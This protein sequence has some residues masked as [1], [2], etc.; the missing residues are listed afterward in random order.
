MN[1]N[2][3]KY[4]KKINRFVL[5]A[6]VALSVTASSIPAFAETPETSFTGSSDASAVLN[7]L[8]YN[9]VRN[10]NTWAKEAIYEQ[11]ALDIIKGFGSQTF[12]LNTTLSKEQAISIA[13]R[14]AG[15][16]ADAQKAAEA[17]DYARSQ[18]DKKTN[19]ISMWS[20]GYLQLAA[21]EGLISQTDLNDAFTQDQT[22]L[23]ATA[24][25]RS[26]PAQRQEMAFYIAKVLK[27]DPAYE[28]QE[29]FNS[30]SDWSLA[31]PTKVPYIEAVLKNN[32]MNGSN[33]HF[34][35]TQS[36][37]REQGAQ[38]AKNASDI[39]LPMRKFI[40]YSGVI[41]DKT[42][43]SDVSVSGSINRTLLSVRNSNGN[44]HV[45]NADNPVN[46]SSM[47]RNEANGQYVPNNQKELVVYR[48]G[49]IGNS[50]LLR[51]GDS[52]EYITT[53]D[54]TVKFV[55]VIN[56][57]SSSS[58]IAV[59]FESIDPAA[60]K[61]TVT[62]LYKTNS[63]DGTGSVMNSSISG[64][65]AIYSF[66]NNV[67]VNSD[68]GISGINEITSG[69]TG[70]VT[71]NN[72]IV[73]SIRLSNLNGY[74]KETGVVSGIVQDNNPQLG[75]IT[76]YNSDGS[77][78]DP[79]NEKQLILGRTYN[80]NTGD[81][82]V[83]KNHSPA[84]I[85]DIEPG[86]T[87]FLKTDEVGTVVS[88]SAVDNYQTKYAK[89][90]SKKPSSIAVRFDDGSQQILDVPSQTPVLSD[91]KLVGYGSVKDG[92]RVR[93]MLHI[94]NGFTRIKEIAIEGSKAGGQLISNVYKGTIS[95]L[96]DSKNSLVVQNVQVFDNG[97][98]QRT[99]QKGF[100]DIKLSKDCSIYLNDKVIDTKTL[101]RYS[102]GNEAYI[103]VKKDYGN[104]ENAV[105]VS[106]RNSGDT[107][108]L[109]DDSISNAVP[110]SNMFS[111]MNSYKTVSYGPGS[112]II[113]DGRLVTGSSLT[114]DDSAYIVANLNN[115]GTDKY[116]AGVVQVSER[117][118]SNFIQI[119]RARISNINENQDFTVESF[120]QL[121]GNTWQYN[122]T[123]KT[124]ILKSNTR[125]LDD[126]GVVNQRDFIS[127]GDSSYVGKVVYILANNLDTV[128]ISEAPF[129]NALVKGTIY[130]T[131]NGGTGSGSSGTATFKLRNAKA[132]NPNTNLWT[133][134]NTITIGTLNDTIVIKNNS[135]AT[136]DDLKNGD[137]IRV[138]KA[139]NTPTGNGY[140][141]FV[142]K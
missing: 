63:A 78:T 31:D 59:R 49:Q 20:D 36:L 117:P 40:K 102:K 107:E 48:N 43:V 66:S 99:D 96:N 32:I 46:S 41:E 125:I 58:Y 33:G 19:A 37:T 142:E 77:G 6:A 135:I 85:E 104:E 10:S 79:D 109:Y 139:D 98:W 120:S 28:Q 100:K 83:Q 114:G 73:T 42:A 39:V 138:I 52:I 76:L 47:G 12:G 88:I 81:L 128:M 136:V 70:V 34:Y 95:Y 16:E 122:N 75:Y 116:Y 112:I 45:I 9:D 68:D 54:N 3:T 30:Y 119:Y 118:N 55:N 137:S 27:L 131:S 51:T 134:S 24:F 64:T 23:D 65:P 92:D 130:D 132:F 86:D 2:F 103:A 1:K 91:N 84:A 141:I 133:D 25:H 4:I 29:I 22:S 62:Q 106:F 14:M 72:G 105:M 97:R 35:P 127:Y 11:G 115:Y 17:L 15:R 5:S 38:I 126:S 93:L 71:V 108:A 18:D 113:K 101:S 67:T 87:V 21:N 82:D 124:F 8:R 53:P 111:L 69:A 123:P 13:Y 26:A 50:S 56:S 7:N 80:Y 121:N 89:V 129:G 61:L 110:G 90:I 44:L 57:S 94:T 74:N 140:I 60:K